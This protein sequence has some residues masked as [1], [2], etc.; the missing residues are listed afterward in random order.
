MI[1]APGILLRGQREIV[2][3]LD[4]MAQLYVATQHRVSNQLVSIEGGHARAGRPT[5]L[6]IT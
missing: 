5:A 3:A 2:A 4:I 6:P 1:E